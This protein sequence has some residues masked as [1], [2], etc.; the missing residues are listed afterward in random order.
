VLAVLWIVDGHDVFFNANTATGGDMGAHV[1]TGDFV[2][3]KLLM[4]GRLTGW[5]DDWFAGFPVLGFYFP[6]P[7]WV[8]TALQVLLP[9]NI[10]FKIVTVLGLLLY[11][12]TGWSLGHH[13]GLR[14]PLPVFLGLATIP[15]MV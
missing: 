2:W 7:F 3:R 11:P 12:V 9:Y 13:A 6:L 15:Y 4:Q 8:M 5:S 1:W 10:A 14:K